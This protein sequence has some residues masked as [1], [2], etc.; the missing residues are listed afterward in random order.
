MAYRN[1]RSWAANVTAFGTVNPGT[2]IASQAPQPF[3]T[4]GD[5]VIP[6][7]VKVWPVKGKE[8]HK[9]WSG[10]PVVMQRDFQAS[11][12]HGIP[13]NNKFSRFLELN[14]L[15]KQLYLITMFPTPRRDPNDPDGV[16]IF[17]FVVDLNRTT[18]VSA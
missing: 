16:L 18:P 3:T 5:R 7:G 4:G 15:G 17:G 2:V 13:A 10:S 1:R 9:L 6:S 12:F 8:L 14:K 11:A